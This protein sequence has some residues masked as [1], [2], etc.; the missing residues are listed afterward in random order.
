MKR[1]SEVNSDDSFLHRFVY[2]LNWSL[3]SIRCMF[4]KSI[5]ILTRWAKC[6][7]ASARAW[8]SNMKQFN[9]K[10]AQEMRSKQHHLSNQQH[11]IR[12]RRAHITSL[13]PKPRKTLPRLR[14]QNSS[15]RPIIL[16]SKLLANWKSWFHKRKR[17]WRNLIKMKKNRSLKKEMRKTKTKVPEEKQRSAEGVI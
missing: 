2:L 5:K 16:A 17:S 1:T 7:R 11:L 10:K 14:W 3:N 12:R 6:A 9:E 15:W 8:G 13:C 4:L